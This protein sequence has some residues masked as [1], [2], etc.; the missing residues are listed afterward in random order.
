MTL[1]FMLALRARIRAIYSRPVS[2]LGRHADCSGLL[3]ETL[4]CFDGRHS[5]LDLRAALARITGP[6]ETEDIARHLID[7]PAIAGF[8]EDE[9]FARTARQEALNSLRSLREPSHAGSA[10]PEDPKELRAGR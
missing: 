8:L 1:D 2:L 10:Y 5:D 6:T 7:T 9:I 3:V 4:E